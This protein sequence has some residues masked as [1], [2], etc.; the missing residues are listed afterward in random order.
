MV[1]VEGREKGGGPEQGFAQARPYEECEC[2]WPW[3][4]GIFELVPWKKFILLTPVHTPLLK[5]RYAS[6]IPQLPPSL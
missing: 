1:H 3:M 4:N 6:S 5:H 2:T